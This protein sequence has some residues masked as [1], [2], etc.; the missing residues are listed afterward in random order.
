MN[1]SAVHAYVDELLDATPPRPMPVMVPMPC[2][3]P[4]I[5]SPSQSPPQVAATSQPSVDAAAHNAVHSGRWLRLRVGD[6][7]YAFALLRVQEVVRPSP[8]V[9]LRGAAPA[10]LGAMNLR[11]RIVPVYDLGLWLGSTGAAPGEH[12]RV[13][14]VERGDVLIGVLAC[15]VEDVFTI[16]A[17]GIETAPEAA[18]AGALLGIARPGGVPV[19]LLDAD[20]LFDQG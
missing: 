20:V 18:S 2:D 16:D 17:A 19:V 11:G 8:I 3:P 5:P 7:R 6:G 1:A 14:I 9:A 4:S 13:V 10:L 12:A 15:A